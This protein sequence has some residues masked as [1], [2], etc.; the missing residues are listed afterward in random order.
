MEKKEDNVTFVKLVF[1]PKLGL[2]WNGNARNDQDE[3]RYEITD[4]NVAGAVNGL[5]FD[6]TLTVLQNDEDLFIL[7]SLEFEQYAAGA[8]MI[9]KEQFN[10]EYKTG[11]ITEFDNFLL[12]RETI[13]SYSN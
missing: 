5:A 10:G 6:S 13:V 9:F 12:Y 7:R 8:G 3:K 2:D 1:P 4:V 11:S